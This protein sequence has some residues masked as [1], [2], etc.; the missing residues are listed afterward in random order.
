[1]RQ[2]ALLITTMLLAT[3]AA[4]STYVVNSLLDTGDTNPGDN[5]C[6]ATSGGIQCTLRAAIEEANAHA[7]NDTITFSLG[8]ITI[9]ITGSALPTIVD[10]LTIDGSTA[11]NYA[12]GQQFTLDAPPSIYINGSGLAG[13][14][15]DGFRIANG[16]SLSRIIA[17]GIIGFPDNGIEVVNTDNVEIDSN[18]I[19]IGRTGGIAANDGSGVYL[20]DCNACIV[21][22]AINPVGPTLVGRG[23]IINNNLEDGVF[24][25]IGGSNKIAGNYIGVD[26]FLGTDQGNNGH[27]IHLQGP[28]NFVGDTVNALQAPNYVANNNGSGLRS[29]TG[30]HR[31]YSNQFFKNGN[32]GVVL[33]GSG[34]RLGFSTASQGNLIHSNTGHG[35]VIGGDFSSPTNEVKRNRIWA[36]SQRG[37]D[38]I[39]GSGNEISNNDIYQ[40]LDDAIRI[41]ASNTIVSNNN[42]GF[43]GNTLLGNAANGIVLSSGSNTIS[44]N[45]IAGVSDDGIDITAGAGNQLTNNR[46]GVGATGQDYGNAANGVRVRNGPSNTRFDSN[47]IGHNNLDGVLLEGS[48][49]TLCDNSIG[50]SWDYT[51]AGNSVEGVR[52]L[53]GGNR[54]GGADAGCLANDIGNNGSD[55]VQVEGDANIIR[56]NFIG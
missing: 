29:V 46:I 25:I 27:G 2:F 21:G 39:Q 26:P 52:I 4:A 18:W 37:V 41:Q 8:L 43:F 50:M 40:N 55:G 24:V 7:G 23:N 36:N 30:G 13:T 45:L 11:P 14:S 19:G 49:S 28:N 17:I 20:N 56:D 10:R 9:N 42:I 38:V 16:L 33:N 31:I 44:G 54:I 35:V 47:A 1:M 6:E 53:G 12:A 22:Q 34:T 51:P 5:V 32:N 48:G 15:A 3:P